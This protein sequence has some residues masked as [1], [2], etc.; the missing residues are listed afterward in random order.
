MNRRQLVA[1]NEAIGL[2]ARHRGVALHIRDDE[3]ELGAAERLDAA[4][5]VDHF[6]R[7]FCRGDAAHPDLRHA[8]GGRIERADIDRVGGPAAQRH[9]AECAGGEQPAALDQEFAA[10]LPLRQNGIC[11]GGVCDRSS[12]IFFHV[13]FSPDAMAVRS[14][15]A[16]VRYWRAL[17]QASRL[18]ASATLR[19]RR[20]IGGPVLLLAFQKPGTLA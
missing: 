14:V 3:I 17:L 12:T 19:V 7:E 4:G 1:G 15:R 11:A 10:A 6:D 16:L 20:N 2:G 9:C 18:A 13:V 5:L 8:P